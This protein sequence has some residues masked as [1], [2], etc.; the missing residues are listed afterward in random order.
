MIIYIKYY[1]LKQVSGLGELRMKKT[2]DISCDLGEG[3][4]IYSLGKDA[5]VLPYISSANIAC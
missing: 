5:A 1:T 3:F 4:G 2:I